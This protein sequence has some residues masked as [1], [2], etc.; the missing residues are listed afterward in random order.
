MSKATIPLVIM[1]RN[2]PYAAT[3]DHSVPG[4]GEHF[5]GRFVP[6]G[7]WNHHLA[8]HN[9]VTSVFPNPIA[10]RSFASLRL[11]ILATV[12]G[13][14]EGLRNLKAQIGGRAAKCF[15]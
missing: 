5:L 3:A 4:I 12:T 15:I 6:R 13:S 1:L 2:N 7:I 9:K 14:V 8:N 11:L 10:T